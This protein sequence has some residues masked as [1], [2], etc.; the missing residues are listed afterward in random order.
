[1]GAWGAK[2]YQDDVAQDVRDYFKDQLRRG[3]T[4]QEL[5]EELIGEYSYLIDDADDG[6]VFWFALADTQ[7]G[8]GRLLP[9]VKEQALLWLDKGGDVRR[10]EAE[11]PKQAV[12]RKKV[13][14]DLHQKLLS[15]QPPEKKVSQYR[16]YT[17]E[18]NI[19]DVFAYRLESD[20]AK[21]KGLFGRYFLIQKVD[22]GI[23]HPG[24]IVPIVY[25][26][27]TNDETLPTS[28]EEY[29]QL[30]YIQTIASDFNPSLVGLITDYQ[31][32]PKEEFWKLV[33]EK[34]AELEFDE[35][36]YL[37]QFRAMLG[38]TSKRSIP[39]K[40]VFIGCFSN[41]LK[42]NKEFVPQDKKFIPF[43]QWKDFENHFIDRYYGHTL[44][45]Y[46]FYQGTIG[47]A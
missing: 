38:N 36:G 45:R 32:L 8:L 14:E 28:A 7:W 16:L 31:S 34:R 6:P 5:T 25:V 33:E 22:E 30:E 40:L 24:H 39:S 11:D 19:G 29:E 13:L 46:R 18:W 37:P 9:K 21:E 35:Y 47:T 44:R 41:T 20:L 23:W 4:A 2:L 10:W 27:I 26:K 42:P 17:C 1:M 12:T 15:P 3:K 43:S